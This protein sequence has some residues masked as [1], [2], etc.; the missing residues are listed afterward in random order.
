M[1]AT[2]SPEALASSL[3]LAFV[4]FFFTIILKI[5][6][7]G[8]KYLWKKTS[9]NRDTIDKDSIDGS[10]IYVLTIGISYPLILHDQDEEKQFSA[11]KLYDLVDCLEKST[12]VSNIRSRS[13]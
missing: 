10:T 6:F 2:I 4:L 3:F 1:R 7:R 5:F 11:C 12:V 8:G 9:E 13:N